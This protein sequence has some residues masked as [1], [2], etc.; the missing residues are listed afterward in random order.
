MDTRKRIAVATSFLILLAVIVPRLRPDSGIVAVKARKIYTAASGVIENGLILVDNGKITYVGKVVPV[1]AGAREIQAEVVLPG[2]VDP[3]SHL[4]VYSVP[5]VTENQDG[6]EMTAALTPEVRALDSFNFEDPALRAALAGG[7]TTIVSRPGSANVI[8]GTSVAVKLRVSTPTR[9][10][11]KEVCD[12]KMTI[13]GNPVAFQGAQNRMPM[14]L[15][16]AYFLARKSFIEAQDYMAAWDAY[17]KDRAA[18]KDVLPPKR[19]LGKDA[20]VMALKREIP[21]HIHT[22]TASEIMSCIRL[23]DEFHLRLTLAHCHFAFL[24]TDDLKGRRDIHFNVGPAWFTTYYDD[25]S[26]IRNVAAILANAGL[27]VSLQVDAGMGRQPAQQYLLHAAGLC[28]RH[29]MKEDDALKAITIRGAEAAGLEAR[30]G[31]LEVGKDADMIFLDGE[32][33][34]WLTSVDR[35]M[36]DGKIEYARE[37]EERRPAIEGLP[38]AE[39]PLVLPA[40]LAASPGYAIAAGTILT[41]AGPPI[42][43]GVILVKDG[44][45]E[46][47]GKGIAIPKGWPVIDARRQVVMPGFVSPRSQVGISLNWRLQESVDEMSNPVVPEMEVK[48][49]IEPQDVLFSAAR[50]VGVT[51]LQV[52]P[53]DR[54]AVGGQGVVIK[55][56]GSVVDKMVVKDRSVMIFGL[57]A[58]AKR[59]SQMPSTR[60]GI[61]ALLRENLVAAREYSDRLAKFE[62]GGASDRPPRDFSLEALVPVV[63]GEMPVMVH[64]E[65]EDDILTA[66][67]IADEFHLRI[68]L[69]GGAEAHKVADEL[70]KRNIPVIIDKIFRAGGNTEDE[71]FDPRNLA[72][73]S[74]AGVRVSFTLGDYLAWYIPLGLVGADPLEVAAFAFKNGLSEEAALEAVTLEAARIIGCE[75]RVG[76]LEPGKD[77]DILVLSGHPFEIR[78]LPEAVFIGGKLVY[79][80]TKGENL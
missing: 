12:L 60:M 67:R 7:V 74:K 13:E 71:D 45:I 68:I 6:N 14:T 28:V 38:A 30:V 43:D 32:P 70:K 29:G 57:G 62:K 55:T 21:V 50:A 52:T 73:L 79:Q 48:N 53:G 66:L 37:A 33:F 63:R 24:L 36:I 8:G 2:L 27:N 58:T 44:K 3:H 39:S 18:G 61:A 15:M 78:S 56:V 80:R 77:A 9:M 49:A 41:M 5:D 59:K 40:G 34:D 42:H 35:V 19:D 75:K 22:A 4:G 54:N 20:L 72:I 69:T 51:T 64:C 17:N 25:P 11:F 23:A 76:S 31:S 47:V 65:R 26:K 10:V 1:P 46:K 16:A